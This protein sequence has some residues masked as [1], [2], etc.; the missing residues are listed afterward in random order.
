VHAAPGHAPFVRRL[1]LVTQQ[2][3]GGDPQSG[4]LFVFVS[5]SA[6]RAKVLWFDRNGYCRLSPCVVPPS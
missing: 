4:A 2:L 3:L 1:A 6:S 5:K